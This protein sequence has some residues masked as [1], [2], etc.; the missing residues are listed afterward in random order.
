MLRLPS[1]LICSYSGCCRNLVGP[2]KERVEFLWNV[3]KPCLKYFHD[4]VTRSYNASRLHLTFGHFSHVLS[5][6][7]CK[8]S[9]TPVG[10]CGTSEGPLSALTPLL[11]A[12]RTH[13]NLPTQQQAQEPTAVE[14]LFRSGQNIFFIVSNPSRQYL[15]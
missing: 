2:N 1:V 13:A 14:P 15:Y 10:S 4:T 12:N 7:L 11:L 8:G 3:E 9:Q 5:L 6:R